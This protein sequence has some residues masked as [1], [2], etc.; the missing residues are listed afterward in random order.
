MN[1][2]EQKKNCKKIVDL[3][4]QLNDFDIEDIKNEYKEKQTKIN[5]NI[6][7]YSLK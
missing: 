1:Y 4:S 5:K 2:V 6:K 3:K 7:K